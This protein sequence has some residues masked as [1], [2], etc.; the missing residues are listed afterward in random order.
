M[1]QAPAQ[2]NGNYYMVEN[3]KNSTLSKNKKKTNNRGATQSIGFKNF[4]VNTI[5]NY[6]R[7]ITNDLESDFA[8]QQVEKPKKIKKTKKKSIN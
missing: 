5:S 1:E 2:P 8:D 3:N 4:M 7:Y 6:N